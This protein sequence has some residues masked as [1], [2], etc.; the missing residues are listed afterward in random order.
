MPKRTAEA[1]WSGDLKNGVGTTG[2]P[3][4]MR[5]PY[6]YLSR[7]ETGGG[8]NPE[9]SLGEAHAA[10][11][12]MALAHSLSQAGFKPNRIHTKADVHLEKAGEGF[13]IARI[14]LNAEGDVPGID[15]NKFQSLAEEA[16]QNCPVSKALAGVKNITLNAKLLSEASSR[17]YKL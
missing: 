16:K 2:V 15:P 11:F 9:E 5:R 7:F 17:P 6:S 1:E 4:P 8:T 3:G 10:C 12:S 14:D 13:E